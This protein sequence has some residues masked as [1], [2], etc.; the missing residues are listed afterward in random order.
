MTHTANTTGVHDI[1]AIIERFG[2]LLT[3]FPRLHPFRPCVLAGLGHCLY[4]RYLISRQKDYLDTAILILTEALLPP[5]PSGPVASRFFHTTKVFYEL[6]CCLAFRFE[7]ARNPVDLEYA[8]KYCRYILILPPRAVVE[9]N[10]L[11]VL[12]NLVKLVA[13]GIETETV[14]SPDH[15]EEI[16]GFLQRFVG[17][18]PS[19]QHIL[20]ILEN[21]GHMLIRRLSQCDQQECEH[22]L[23]LIAEIEK[24][25]PYERF[26]ELCISLGG[27]SLIC[28]HLT[29]SNDH[30]KQAIVQFNKALAL[31][32][33]E[34]PLR[35][36]AQIGLAA[37]HQHRFTQYRQLEC[38]E[39]SID[40]FRAALSACPPGHQFHPVC[41]IYLAGSL[42]KR[43]EFFGNAEFMREADSCIDDA[44]RVCQD[45]PEEL[46]VAMANYI[47]GV[48]EIK[49]FHPVMSLEALTKEIERRQDRVARMSPDQSSQ[50]S[51]LHSLAGAWRDKFNYTDELADLEEEINC[52]FMALAASPLNHYV[53][54]ASLFSLGRAFQQRF[55]L[56]GD[57][58]SL[59]ESIK[60]CREAL[61]LC[62]HGHLSRIEPL[63]T[64]AVSLT[65]RSVMLNQMADVDESM[66]L[67]RSA[68]DEEYADPHV[69][70]DIASH[71]AAGARMCMHP[72]TVLAYEKAMSLM[73]SAFALGPT[74]EIQHRLLKGR[75][76]K[77]AQ[78][79]LQ[80]ASFHIKRGSLAKAKL[81]IEAD[82]LPLEKAV[83]SLERGRTLLWSEMRGLRMPIDQLWASDDATLAERYVAISR[84]LE[85]ITTSG[86]APEMDPHKHV[87]DDHRRLDSFG[88]MMKRVRML[89]R[90]R[91]E[92]IDQIRTLPGFKDFLKAIPFETLQTAAACGPVIIINHCVFRCDILIILHSAAPVLIPTTERF[93]TRTAQL[94]KELLDTRA[95]YKL[96]SR[97]YQRSLRSVLSEL[98]ELVG[99]PVLEK[100]HELG[101]PEQ[102]RVWWCPTS[103]LCSLPLH[104][105]G[106]IE[107]EGGVKRYFSDLYVS[108][109][110]PSLS[111]LIESRKGITHTIEPPSLLIVGDPSLPGVREEIE[112]IH[113][114][115]ATT[116]IGPQATRAMVMK[117]LPNHRMVHFACHGILKLEQP[118]DTAFSLY[119]GDRLSLL[120]I[121]RSHLSG[122]EFAFL[123][124]CHAAE[125]TDP[126][127]PDEALHLTAA[128]QHCGF[129]SAVGTLWAMADKDGCYLSEHFYKRMFAEDNRGVFIGERS[130]RALRDSVQKLRNKK[131]MTLERWVN[132][133]HYGA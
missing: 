90:E 94:K 115:S 114:Q 3:L 63:R 14:P 39:E 28:F 21:I 38:L 26:P 83:E 110:T 40:H 1:G 58:T 11:E 112:V 29:D 81:N 119:G 20:S 100:L 53:R 124:A 68:C 111:A 6:A 56:N 13:C 104:A 67:F 98:Y 46:R 57:M 127:T 65:A 113:V 88:R 130:A 54:R 95:T 106:P 82:S 128:M 32:P 93:Y 79:P 99:R 60:Y 50:L 103:V 132:F 52:H 31:L 96:E 41:L 72:S 92:I 101:I 77:L 55:V 12:D 91:G 133:V 129:R 62:P 25:C 23:S 5:S 24:L 48:K 109:Y 43:Y 117:H 59:G 76:G 105:A 51:N 42:R 80:C 34:H 8:I 89:E 2:A 22:I 9:I 118:F 87:Q 78:V 120:D 37:T 102:S 121:V 75:W 125:W 7:L 126:R 69:R 116:L 49:G 47:D 35:P 36:K 123:S 64:L 70:Y 61:E 74:L 71:W 19:S 30:C 18:D 44:L 122:A 15:A 10:C 86:E 73:Q 97:Q 17:V 4:Y 107:S 33:P 45:W 66:E 85:D 108:S 27:A 84:E 131:E 16:I